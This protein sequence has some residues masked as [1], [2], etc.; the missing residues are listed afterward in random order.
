MPVP[1]KDK[2]PTANLNKSFINQTKENNEESD[3]CKWFYSLE[4]LSAITGLLVNI[5]TVVTLAVNG[6]EFPQ[7]GRILLQHQAIADSLVCS[8][9]IVLLMQ[10]FMWVTGNDT[11]DF[12]VCQV[13]HSQAIYWLSVYISIW[14]LV[15]IAFERFIMIVFPFKHRNI[16]PTHIYS[17]FL[18]MYSSFVIFTSPVWLPSRYDNTKRECL[19]SVTVTLNSSYTFELI[20]TVSVFFVQY[21]VP[22]AFFIVLYT[23]IILTLR[24]RQENLKENMGVSQGSRLYDIA[25]QQMTRTVIAVTIFFVV[26]LSFDSWY[27]LLSLS[28]GIQYDVSSQFQIIGTFLVTVNSGVNPFIYCTSMPIFRKS[29]NKTFRCLNLGIHNV[30]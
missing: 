27:F 22:I 28:D 29:L 10:P 21:A 1:Y 2:H 30:T 19:R 12:L 16:R 17:A 18:I 5:I 6:K 13:W 15:F 7:I 25:N 23:K 14:N 11:V 3:G 8:M 24:Q 4:T 26:S 9:G 20:Y